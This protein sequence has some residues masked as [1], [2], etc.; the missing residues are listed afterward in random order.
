MRWPSASP[1]RTGGHAAAGRARPRTRSTTATGS[2]GG[3]WWSTWPR[4]RPTPGTGR[5]WLAPLNCSGRIRGRRRSEPRWRPGVRVGARRS[6]VRH[7]GGRRRMA[8]A[9]GRRLRVGGLA[10]ARGAG[11]GPA[12]GGLDPPRPGRA[13]SD[14]GDGS[15]TLLG[16]RRGRPPRTGPGVPAG[17]GTKGRRKKAD[18]VGPGSL[19]AREAEVATL[20]AQGRRPARSR[21]GCSSASGRSRPTSPTSTPSSASPRRSSW[22]GGRPS[23]GSEAPYRIP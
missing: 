6:C 12:R 20:A 4:W 5:R 13:R 17:L 8:R 22:C 9:G 23:W 1:G 21:R 19:S 14:P 16:V 7:A 15:R 18:L 2:G 11:A 3:G 10:T